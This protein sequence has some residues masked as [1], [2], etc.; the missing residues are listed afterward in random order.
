MLF[1]LKKAKIALFFIFFKYLS[2]I[3]NKKRANAF[4]LDRG[5][6]KEIKYLKFFNIGASEDL[7]APD[8]Q[9]NHYEI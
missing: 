4:L 2:P 9:K 7:L 8:F 1:W 6:I 3:S 5:D